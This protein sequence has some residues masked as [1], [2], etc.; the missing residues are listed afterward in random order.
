ML[1]DRND[2]TSGWAKLSACEPQYGDT[3]SEILT[4][5]LCRSTIFDTAYKEVDVK[6][7]S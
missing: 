1:G 5:C 2:S 6:R 4:A 7:S 3:R